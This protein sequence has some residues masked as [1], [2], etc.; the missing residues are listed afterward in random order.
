MT[1]AEIDRKYIWHPYTQMLT[2]DLPVEIIQAKDAYL[3][4]SDGKKIIDAVSS[5]WTINY[6][7][8]HP[9]IISKL[10]E[11]L[12]T[13]DH[14]IFA[15]FT[16]PKAIE[17]A[18]KMIQILPGS[19]EKVFFSDNG[20]TAVEV[21]VK[22][23]IQYWQ[24]QEKP[25]RK[26][27]AIEGA[28]HGDTFG[29]MSVSARN[30][31]N[32]AFEKYLFD[33]VYIPFPSEQNQERTVQTLEKLADDD[34]IAFIYEP[35]VQGAAGMR[36][37]SPEILNNLM[38]ICRQKNILCIADE[39]FT[40]FGRTGKN[41]ASEYL[42]FQPDIMCFSK[43]LTGGIMPMGVTS[44]SQEIYDAFLSEN[45][46]SKTF[47]HGHSFTGNPLQCTAAA[48][49]I[50]LLTSAQIQDDITRISEKQHTFA[51]EL[52]KTFP[53]VQAK[54]LGTILSVEIQTKN[55]GYFNT[56][57]N[58]V[59]AFFMANNI[60]IRPL[61]NVFYVLPPYCISNEDL[62]YI[63]LKIKKFLSQS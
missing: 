35:L 13:L 61:G 1:L 9:Y 36:I 25:R 44:C 34:T 33:V 31:F 37:Y 12:Q 6:G 30:A 51:A 14:V 49:S 41:F 56:L 3:F 58:K 40:G 18:E 17:F 55:A 47:F 39:V 54:S 2:A 8:C 16:H 45:D 10:T 53:F 43:G 7:H 20:S 19:Q 24:N 48:A 4:T 27:I 22:M 29:A 42:H 5:W 57:R 38:E 50:D 63:Y 26:I 23:A 21:A 15:G 28:Y 62:D 11:Q 32:N 52:D 60:L 59:Y 46:I